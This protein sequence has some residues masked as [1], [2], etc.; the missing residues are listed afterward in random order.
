MISKLFV[1]SWEREAYASPSCRISALPRK[2]VLCDSNLAG[3]NSATEE[4]YEFD[5]E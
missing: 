2:Y 3:T 4:E 1:L 5:W